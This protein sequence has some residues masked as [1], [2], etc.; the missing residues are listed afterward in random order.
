MVGADQTLWARWDDGPS[1]EGITPLLIAVLLALGLHLLLLTRLPERLPASDLPARDLHAQRGISFELMKPAAIQSKPLDLEAEPPSAAPTS[2]TAQTLVNDPPPE[3]VAPLTLPVEPRET[4]PTQSV[5]TPTTART[6]DRLESL[7]P[8]PEPEPIRQHQPALSDLL[9]SRDA[10]IANLARP[11]TESLIR[12]GGE[13]RLAVDAN[14]KDFRYASYLDA[15]QRKVERIGN[16][17]YPQEARERNLYGSLVVQVSVRADGSLAGVQVLRSSGEP[18]LDQAAMGIVRLAA[19]FAP[20]P[21]TIRAETDVLD[22]TRGWQFKRGA[23][24]GASR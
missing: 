5:V 19:P 6:P 24:F 18:L 9:K 12:T 14:T 2:T 10:A 8:A 17:N 7:F 16:L 20:L 11:S 3:T 21:D 22:I 15:W 4:V 23:G 13:R 1:A